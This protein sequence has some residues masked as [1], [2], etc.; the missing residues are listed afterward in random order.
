MDLY[1]GKLFDLSKRELVER[2]LEY[3][4][5][6]T[7][8]TLNASILW[9]LISQFQAINLKL[10]E[11]EELYRSIIRAMAEG[12]VI[13]DSSGQI[14]AGNE[15]A[16]KIL[17]LSLD[18]F[19]G[20]TSLDPRWKAIR[21]DG[22]PFHG[23][24]HPAMIT[25]RTG[26]SLQNVIM[27]VHKIN[28]EL[29]WISIN[30]QPIFGHSPDKPVLV[31]ST[32]VDITERR[33][34]EDELKRISVTDHLTQIFNRVKFT[35]TLKDE[36]L[37]ADRYQVPLSLIMFDIDNFKQVNDTHGHDAGDYVLVEVVKIVQGMIR[38]TDLFA[39]WGGEEFIL[40]LPNTEDEDAF[41]LAERIRTAVDDFE[42]ETVGSISASF[43]VTEYSPSESEDECTK[44]LDEALYRAKDLGR[45]R[46]ES[47]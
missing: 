38:D 42:F 2:L 24:E 11:S 31:V 46:V 29:A 16:E 26:K 14:L 3:T 35:N 17:G 9:D 44:R 20:R 8:Q 21:E 27:G 7:D 39:R 22:S 5:R 37:R 6:E 25:L 30:S 36:I 43:G 28:G 12:V 40:L 10:E 34:W 13:Q 23:S 19:S 18:Q 45:N 15:S 33:I 32:F 47:L 1:N 4:A 41:C